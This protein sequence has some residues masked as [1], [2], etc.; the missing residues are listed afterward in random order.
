MNW[1]APC[2]LV[3]LLCAM[4]VWMIMNA[5]EWPEMVKRSTPLVGP[6]V[7]GP[8]AWQSAIVN[9]SRFNG[10]LT[11]GLTAR[12]LYIAPGVLSALVKKPITIGIE[13]LVF[14]NR[15]LH[16]MVVLELAGTDGLYIA[17]DERWVARIV[18]WRSRLNRPLKDGVS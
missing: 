11:I 16:D 15:R 2:L 8:V 4:I 12:Q 9:G 1:L 10:V 14:S 13:D 17:L 18:E 5:G 7:A 6:F 3:G